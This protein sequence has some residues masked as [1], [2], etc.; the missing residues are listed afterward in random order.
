M[1]WNPIGEAEASRI[2]AGQNRR[3]TGRADGAGGVRIR[4][5][6]ALFAQM[7]ETGSLVK[8]AA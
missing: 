7:V 3:P 5:S 6:H 4:K 8:L 1:T 2:L